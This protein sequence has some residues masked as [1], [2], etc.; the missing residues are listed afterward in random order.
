MRQRGS[1]KEQAEHRAHRGSPNMSLWL[2]VYLTHYPSGLD[3]THPRSCHQSCG[4]SPAEK[5]ASVWDFFEGKGMCCYA[6]GK[7]FYWSMYDGTRGTG[8]ILSLRTRAARGHHCSPML[9]DGAT[10]GMTRVG[11]RIKVR[12]VTWPGLRDK[13]MKGA[14]PGL[15]YSKHLAAAELRLSKKGDGEL[16]SKGSQAVAAIHGTSKA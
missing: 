4:C 15:R 1:G 16:R 11:M 5:G 13:G 12:A 2:T 8:P 7:A 10:Q 6:R 9:S 14:A 3:R